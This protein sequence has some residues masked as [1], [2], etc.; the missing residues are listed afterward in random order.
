M[1][2]SAFSSGCVMLALA[3]VSAL[4]PTSPSAAQVLE[5]DAGGE[6]TTF[7]RPM[8][9]TAT[10]AAPIEAVNGDRPSA[11]APAATPVWPLLDD[12]A[13]R[14]GLPP[15]LLRAV[16]WQ[17][18][19]G[20]TTAV[21]RKGALGVMQLMP[22]TAASLGVDPLNLHQNVRGGALY[23]RRQLDRFGSVPLALAAYNAGPAAVARFGGMPPYRETHAY[24]A[25]IL[26]HWQPDAAD[27]PLLSSIGVPPS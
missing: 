12:A 3:L 8:L 2:T 9:F 6:T 16:A 20:R 19:R 26:A 21:S 15:A 25:S 13:R 14:H 24:V 17:E 7:D 1:T 11:A 4:L 23:L 18:S 10:G 27:V 22:A 5:I